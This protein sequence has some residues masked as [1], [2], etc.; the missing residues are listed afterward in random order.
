MELG[1]MYAYR[2]LALAVAAMMLV[3]IWRAR[4]WRDQLFATL[5]FVPFVLRGLGIK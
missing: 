3:V 1:V 4:N 2:L 5:V